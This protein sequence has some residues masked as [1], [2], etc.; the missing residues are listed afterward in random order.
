M[1]RIISTSIF[2]FFTFSFLLFSQKK[3]NSMTLHDYM[4]NHMETAE[5][6]FKKGDKADLERLLKNVHLLAPEKDREEWQ[7]ITNSHLENGSLMKS[8]K[9]CH[10]KFKKS[11]KKVYKKKLLNI[12]DELLILE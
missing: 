9:A 11:Y 10:S 3:Q 4:E 8:C 5:E 1:N 6:K 2:F 7:K 12:P